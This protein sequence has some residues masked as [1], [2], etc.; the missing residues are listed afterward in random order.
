MLAPSIGF[1]LLMY[2]AFIVVSLI[3]INLIVSATIKWW[4]MGENDE[5]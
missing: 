3:I 5:S 2:G 4:D 1:N